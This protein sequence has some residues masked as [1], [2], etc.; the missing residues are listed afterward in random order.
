MSTDAE[1]MLSARPTWKLWAIGTLA[2]LWN[3]MGAFDYLMTQTRNAA[4]L[5][6]MTPAQM[7]YIDAFPT[8]AIATWATAVWG[9]V[10][11]TVLLLMRR[12]SAVPV[13]LVSLVAMV[14]TTIY[15]YGLSNGLEVF[16]G[17]GPKLFT[18]LIFV[19]ALGLYLYARSLA[20]R[21]VLHP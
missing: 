16:V 7:A 4:Y 14:L 6:N 3:A 2:L 17:T 18:A 19:V 11:G 9:G 5:S 13:F 15:Q 8:W 12:K 10:L 1:A 20:Q 21:G